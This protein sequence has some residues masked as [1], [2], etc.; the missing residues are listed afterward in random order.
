M[1]I[2]KEMWEI[3]HIF[4]DIK[5]MP[6]DN[7]NG[8]KY[9]KH[10]FLYDLKLQIEQL[11]RFFTKY[12]ENNK[13]K[14]PNDTYYKLKTEPNIHQM[15]YFNLGHGFPKELFGGHWCYILKKFKTKYLIIPSTSDDNTN[16]DVEEDSEFSI[17]V[18]DFINGRLTKL[19]V[20][21]ARCVDLQRLYQAKGYYDVVTSRQDIE[22][23]VA[24]ILFSDVDIIKKEA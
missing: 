17:E 12:V 23:S 19:Q 4:H 1:N 22:L 20:R 10:G 11:D 15:A 24:K 9:D 14:N 16:I 2:Y 8:R 7:T 21:N 3:A 13:D 18:K 6:E 5:N